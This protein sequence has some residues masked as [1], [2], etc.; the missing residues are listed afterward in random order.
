MAESNRWEPQK[1]ARRRALQAL[2]QWQMTRQPAEEIIEQ[3]MEAQDFREVD[4]RLFR[5]LVSGV[6]SE[7]EV[8]VEQLAPSVERP[9]AQCDVMERVILLMGAWQLQHQPDLPHQVIL[10][11]SVDL[12]SRFG[13]AQSPGFINGALDHAARAWRGGAAGPV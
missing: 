6:I 8:L 1:R 12:A 10:E 7:H 13:S 4:T 5:D 2:Y 11:E 9:M 3:F